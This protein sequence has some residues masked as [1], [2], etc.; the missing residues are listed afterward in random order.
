MLESR[1]LVL[2]VRPWGRDVLQQ[3]VFSFALSFED[4]WLLRKACGWEAGPILLDTWLLVMLLN[5]E[6]VEYTIVVCPLP[7]ATVVTLQPIT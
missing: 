2:C 5:G 1:E 6:S 7:P 4:R 3:E